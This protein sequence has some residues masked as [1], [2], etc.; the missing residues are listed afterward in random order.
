MRLT[1]HTDY[2]LRILMTLAILEH[3]RL[4]T[5]E[6]LADRHGISA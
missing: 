3:G 4:A 6:E 5:I 1:V 2:A